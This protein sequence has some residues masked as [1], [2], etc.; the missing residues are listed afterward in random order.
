MKLYDGKSLAEEFLEVL[1][2]DGS[3]EG[4]PRDT[5]AMNKKPD[6]LA[7]QQFKSL[8]HIA[9]RYPLLQKVVDILLKQPNILKSWF[10]Q[11]CPDVSPLPHLLGLDPKDPDQLRLLTVKAL[12][13]DRF[14]FA[15]KEFTFKHMGEAFSFNL[16][17]ACDLLQSLG[18]TR[19]P[20]LMLKDMKVGGSCAAMSL[21][22]N[23]ADVC[24]LFFLFFLFS[25]LLR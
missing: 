6:W 25:I 19:R 14:S 1:L 13:P 17:E 16:P 8:L 7:D 24:C 21:I 2:Y 3:L 15:L 10:D 23:L 18:S 12:R 22:E 9:E 11:L 5:D 4:E 20:V